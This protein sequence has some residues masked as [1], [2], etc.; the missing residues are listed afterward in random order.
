MSLFI[1]RQLFVLAWLIFLGG[2]FLCGTHDYG[3]LGEL[4]TVIGL[5]MAVVMMIVSGLSSPNQI[6]VGGRSD[7][8]R[9][10]L[11]VILTFVLICLVVGLVRHAF[12]I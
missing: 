6:L 3:V 11:V 12:K 8:S 9:W 1:K 2:L 4:V 7:W 5:G 10:I